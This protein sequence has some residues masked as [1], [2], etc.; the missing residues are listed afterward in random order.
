MIFLGIISGFAS[1]CLV[2]TLVYNSIPSDHAQACMLPAI[3]GFI[4]GA[5]P[6]FHKASV[7]A[8]NLLHPAPMR[9]SVNM[10]MAFSKMREMLTLLSYKFGDKWNVI[11]ADTNTGRIVAELRFSDEEMRMETDGRGHPHSRNIRVQRYLRLEMELK[12]V[13]SSDTILSLDFESRIEGFNKMA[14]DEIINGVM[15]EIANALGPAQFVG[16]SLSEKISAPPYWL[17]GLTVFSL[18]LLLIDVHKALWGT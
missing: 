7:Q 4:W 11:L 16:S 13:E 12:P 3:V 1:F 6:F 14:C 2:G 18:F 5:W 9:F 10:Q 8:H 15:Q 17:I